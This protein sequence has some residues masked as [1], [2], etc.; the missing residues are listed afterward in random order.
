MSH[1]GR[2]K[3]TVVLVPG[4]N[5]P[6]AD[7]R[8]LAFGRNG[9]PGLA[10]HGFDCLPFD[11]LKHNSLDHRIERL[12]AW[13]EH[14]RR[15]EPWR[16]PLATVGYSV[17]GIVTR[18]LLRLFP[19]A[20]PHVALSVQVAAPNWGVEMAVLP[21]VATLVRLPARAMWD[22]DHHAKFMRRLNGVGGHW[23]GHLLARRWELDGEPEIVPPGAR[24]LA[25]A[26]RAPQY[27]NGDGLIAH[28]AVTLGGRVPTIT[29]EDRDANHLNLAGVSN[30]F[31]TVFR[32]FRRNDR[33]WPRV[34]EATAAALDQAF[35]TAPASVDEPVLR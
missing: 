13:L 20:V 18:G 17:G 12:A 30:P 22:I 29:I 35:A 8:T 23:R 1:S 15:N 11:D 6:S 16:F 4:W 21:F 19:A 28:D 24:L 34:V 10:G 9:I 3:G 31:G 27:G 32:G 7:L 25:I 26:G 33:I 2:S 14:L 5:Q